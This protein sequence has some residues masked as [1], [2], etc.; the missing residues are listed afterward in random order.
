[1]LM[2]LTY[3]HPT[4]GHP[5]REETIRKAK[6]LWRWKGM[7]EWIASYVKGCATCQQNK[8]LTHRKKTPLYWICHHWYGRDTRWFTCYHL[9]WSDSH[10]VRCCV[11]RPGCG[12]GR[13]DS[14][15]WYSQAY[16]PD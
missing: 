2:L 8:I 9:S 7:N 16:A 14:R 1:V 6:K 13:I 3:D 15:S 10:K 11:L 4:A 5:G 12:I